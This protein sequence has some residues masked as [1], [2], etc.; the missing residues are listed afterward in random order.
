[1]AKRSSL[2]GLGFHICNQNKKVEV[3]TS[4]EIHWEKPG[5]LIIHRRKYQHEYQ[6]LSILSAYN[7][8]INNAYLPLFSIKTYGSNSG[9]TLK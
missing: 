1:M 9:S 4:M 8:F 7:T 5:L 2:S 6:I 3:A